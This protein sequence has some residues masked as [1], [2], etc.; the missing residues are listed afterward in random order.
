MDCVSREAQSIFY[1][2]EK[3]DEK[4]KTRHTRQIIPF[5]NCFTFAS[6]NCKRSGQTDPLPTP[7]SLDRPPRCSVRPIRPLNFSSYTICL[8][9]PFLAR[10]IA[11]LDGVCKYLNESTNLCTIYSERPFFCRVVEFYEQIVN[12]HSNINMKCR[13]YPTCLI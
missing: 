8:S 3:K 9:L 5:S 4:K 13:V 10:H 1:S 12:I 6:L 7:A 2:R 11:K